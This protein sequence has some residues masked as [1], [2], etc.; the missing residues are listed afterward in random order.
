MQMQKKACKKLV[1]S[2]RGRKK[3]P[4]SYVMQWILQRQERGC[5]NNLLADLIHTDMQGYQNFVRMPPA[6]FDLIEEC[7]HHHIFHCGLVGNILA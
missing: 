2:P 1:S 3:P 6:F 7:I 4:N 5:C